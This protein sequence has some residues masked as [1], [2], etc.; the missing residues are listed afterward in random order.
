MTYIISAY[1]LGAALFYL[2]TPRSQMMAELVGRRFYY[3]AS[4]V[5]WP[6]QVVCFALWLKRRKR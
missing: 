5:F 6:W 4:V 1:A 3:Y 2:V